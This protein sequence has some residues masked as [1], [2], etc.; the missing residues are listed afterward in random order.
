[1]A[2]IS[3]NPPKERLPGPMPAGRVCAHADCTTPLSR[4]NVGETCSVHGGW[5]RR[6]VTLD[7]VDDLH[8]ALEEARAA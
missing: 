6:V 4:Y 3:P 8:E 1:M 2:T 7:T 5:P